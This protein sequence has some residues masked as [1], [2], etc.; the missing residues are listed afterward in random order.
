MLAAGFTIA[1]NNCRVARC[2]LT[3]DRTSSAVTA[4]AAGSWVG[5]QLLVTN[6]TVAFKMTIKN[7]ANTYMNGDCTLSGYAWIEFEW[8]GSIWREIDRTKMFATLS[9][10]LS[11]AGAGGGHIAS[12]QYSFILSGAGNTATG[13]NAVAGGV[14]CDATARNAFAF[15]YNSDAGKEESVAL[16][17]NCYTN[18]VMG[19]T[20]GSSCTVSNTAG[21]SW[22]TGVY[23]YSTIPWEQVRAAGRFAAD[24]D[25]QR[26]EIQVMA[27][28]T[29][30]TANVELGIAASVAG[31]GSRITIPTDTTWIVIVNMVSTD[32]GCANTGA[33]VLKCNIK[34]AG[35]TV[36]I[37]GSDVLEVISN[38]LGV[39]APSLAADNVNKALSV[40]FTGLA[41]TNLRTGADVRMMQVKFPT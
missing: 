6:N 21:G 39:P 5:Q 18:G 20:Q 17:L 24:G 8:D 30:D 4:I 29:D 26:R 35:G 32:I 10:L 31:G 14:V 22:A 19:L 13:E 23:G 38:E 34:N 33:W 27:A 40:R 3:A 11:G 7:A 2:T 28:T 9:G 12:G 16:G 15:G 37:V 25:S 1:H 41:A 36:S